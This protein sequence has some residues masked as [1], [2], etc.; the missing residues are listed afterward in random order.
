MSNNFENQVTQ[1]IQKIAE[2]IDFNK[3]ADNGLFCG[4][5]GAFLFYAYLH[6]YTDNDESERLGRCFD[7]VQN[8][9]ELNGVSDPTL[10]T[11]IAGIGWTF[12]HLMACGIL[13]K[14]EA[15]LATFDR[16]CIES[17][18][19]LSSQNNYDVWHGFLGIAQYLMERHNE[20][21]MSAHLAKIPDLIWQASTIYNNRLIWIDY[22]RQKMFPKEEARIN[23][24]LAHGISGL[25][26][27][28]ARL[29]DLDINRDACKKLMLHIGTLLMSFKR[30]E[31][32]QTSA[33]YPSAIP[34]SAIQDTNQY[35]SRLG[36]CHGDMG[37]ACAF[38]KA[39]KSLQKEDW[40]NEALF[41]MDH[42]VTRTQNG[43]TMDEP[44]LCHGTIS[45]AHLFNKF[46][47]AT[48]NPT[49]KD[50][51]AYWVNAT[52]KLKRKN[53]ENPTG[54]L[55]KC[56]VLGNNPD[57]ITWGVNYSLI[58]G[59]IGL[60][61]SLLYLTDMAPATWDRILLLDI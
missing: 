57:E 12:Q 21:D 55:Y 34:L 11:G 59:D 5:A 36:L 7:L 49:Y 38:Y 20:N 2:C 3:L 19:A 43:E 39:G 15:M 29:H 56:P 32:R 53:R 42:A 25:L 50:C 4:N 26:S 48:G 28:V 40:I 8:N 51:A 31:P 33:Y 58:D 27:I 44:C 54:F 60:G 6:L 17:F 30:D 52:F 14:D 41:L 10:S 61:L 35:G 22:G 13:E 18:Q 23:L 45:N 37:I 1:T 47:H 24:G 16:I 46:Y 9:L